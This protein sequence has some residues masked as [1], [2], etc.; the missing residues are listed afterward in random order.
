[1]VLSHCHLNIISVGIGNATVSTYYISTNSKQAYRREQSQVKGC[2]ISSLRSE[3]DIG[4][5]GAC[6]APDS[7]W[8]FSAS[9]V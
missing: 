2:I 9:R 6:C 5:K 3:G 7:V 4:S 1:M 8:V